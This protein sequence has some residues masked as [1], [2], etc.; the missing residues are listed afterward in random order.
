MASGWHAASRK[1]KLP[2][3][4]LSILTKKLF[5][6]REKIRTSENGD[7]RTAPLSSRAISILEALPKSIDGRVFPITPNA[8]KMSWGRAC[9]SA[10]IEDFHFHDLRHEATSRLAEKL[11]NLIE[12]ASVTGHKDLQMLKRYYH[13]RAEDLAKK[14]G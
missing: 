9:K 7:S 13:P 12:L 14:L 10:E 5:G 3:D 8:I 11:P 4:L 6:Q 2:V 1:G